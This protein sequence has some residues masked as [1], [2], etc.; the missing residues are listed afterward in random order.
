MVGRKRRSNAA[1]S[2]GSSK[3]TPTTGGASIYQEMLAE[4]GVQGSASRDSINDEPPMK[5]RRS[6]RQKSIHEQQAASG[7]AATTTATATTTT[8]EQSVDNDDD[9]DEDEDEE[10]EFQDVPLP[11]EQVQTIERDSEDDSDE[12]DEDMIFED[13]GLAAALEQNT[14]TSSSATEHVSKDLELNLTAQQAASASA[15][16]NADRRKPI[17]KEERDRRLDVHKMHLLC[18]LSHVARRNHWCNDEQVQETLRAHVSNKTADY[19]TPGPHLPQFGQAESLKTGLKQAGDAWRAKFEVTERGLR[20]ARW[21]ED[22]AQ[23]DRY[24]LP[25]HL[26]TCA[27]RQD[28]RRAAATMQG[29]RDVGAQLYCALLRGVGVRARLVC[30]L[31][32]LAFGNGA[33]TLPKVAET[34]APTRETATARREDEMRSQVT[35]YKEMAAAAVPTSHAGSSVRRRLGH[36]NAASRNFEPLPSP[37]PTKPQKSFAAPVRLRES[38]YPVYWVEVL[39][40]GHQ[41][42][43][44]A[45]PAVTHTF[46]KSKS[47]EPPI[48]DKENCMSYVVAFD[49]D[50]TARDVTVRYAKAYAAKTRRMRVDVAADVAGNNWWRTAMRSFRRRHRTNLDQIED[51]ELVGVEAREPMPRNVQDFKD[52]PVFALLRHLRRHEVLV[53]TATPSGTV[54]SGSKGPLEKIYRR[55]DVRVARSAD[56]WFRM[57][58]EVRPNEIPAKWLPK[59]KRPKYRFENNDDYHRRREEEEDAA[60]VPIYTEDQTEL[61]EPEPVRDGRVPKNKFGNVEVYVPSMVP[62]GGAH[63]EHELAA[64]AARVLGVDYAPALTGFAFQGR[65]GTAV[66]RGAVVAAEHAA[67]VEAVI[68]GL[69]EAER[70][71]EEEARAL[72]ARRWWRRLL[73]GLRIRERVW[74][75]VDETE[76]KE[77][78]EEVDKLLEEADKEDG[79]EGDEGDDGESDE[80]EEFDMVV[81]GGD[82]SDEYGG[83]FLVD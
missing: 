17:T 13:V 31:Q 47:L 25:D 36:P 48:T 81:D 32:P 60:G 72:V 3:A 38:A 7:P 45:D 43:Q 15:K 19:L 66:L 74:A 76:R 79:D 9:D 54:S 21:A 49:E 62:R 40:T 33:P 50:G 57:G 35:Q 41:K 44:P 82:D 11:P 26:E 58:R 23:L 2:R 56:K 12:D 75:G 30:S 8:R 6:G 52:H 22:A 80:T 71:A 20:R 55:R 18:L 28:F 77:A 10:I 1:G 29:S 78:E 67:A 68:A 14:A 59:A 53:P 51:A 73:T 37:S 61:Y 24:R 16:R 42:W 65:Q 70:T 5:R 27:D 69:E 83:G 39:D 64:R 63:V 4:A 46:W 34:T